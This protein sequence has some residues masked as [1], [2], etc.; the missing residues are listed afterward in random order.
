ME[1][2]EVYRFYLDVIAIRFATSGRATSMFK[3]R[4]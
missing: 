4:C 2:K 1:M 3:D